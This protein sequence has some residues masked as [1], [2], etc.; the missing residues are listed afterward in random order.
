M[1]S[2]PPQ[3][4]SPADFYDSRWARGLTAALNGMLQSFKGPITIFSVFTTLAGRVRKQTLVT[5]AT[6]TIL[7]SDDVVDV[8][9]AGACALT[10]PLSPRTGQEWGI[11][12]SSGAARLNGITLAPCA[13][14]NLNGDTTAIDLGV[15]YGMF[16]VRYN[17]TQFIVGVG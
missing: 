7:L 4:P 10:L 12:D 14:K 3:F 5:S 9:Y 17:G 11:Q 16:V 6:Y 8:N 13:G 15:D 2:K 1:I